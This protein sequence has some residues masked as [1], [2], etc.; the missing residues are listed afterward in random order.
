MTKVLNKIL[1]TL[2]YSDILIVHNGFDAVAEA[3]KS[4][5]DL[6]LLD[7]MMPE[8]DGLTTMKMLKTIPDSSLSKVVIC[9]A[10]S[11]IE[12]ITKAMKFGA[13][14]FVTKPFTAETIKE[15]LDKLFL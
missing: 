9:S 5:P 6:I 15:K 11:D 7:L 12:N 3:L 4:K 10:N 14:D 13:E 1:I 8:I 2:G